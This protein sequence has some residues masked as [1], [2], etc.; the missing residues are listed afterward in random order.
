[1]LYV[2]FRLIHLILSVN[3]EKKKGDFS[4]ELLIAPTDNQIV[5]NLTTAFNP[6]CLC[7]LTNRLL[8]GLMSGKIYENL[9]LCLDR[10]HH[11]FRI[12]VQLVSEIKLFLI[13]V[14]YKYRKRS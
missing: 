6:V 10:L 14:L 4:S 7:T 2:R 1:M 11:Q 8:A 5:P 3:S 9:M 12:L 13:T